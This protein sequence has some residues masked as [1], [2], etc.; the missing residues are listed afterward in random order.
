[1]HLHLLIPLALANAPT[2][3]AYSDSD[4]DDPYEDSWFIDDVR[5]EVNPTAIE[6]EPKI[7]LTTELHQNYP[8]PFNPETVIRYSLSVAGYVN[9]AI[10]DIQG[11]VVRRPSAVFRH[12]GEYTF[13]WDAKDDAG[14]AVASGVYFYQ[15]KTDNQQLTRKMILLK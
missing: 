6:D 13:V 12:A 7:P 15:L 1:M 4:A 2:P 11:R 9:L 10:Y 5:L 8:N 3:E 14:D